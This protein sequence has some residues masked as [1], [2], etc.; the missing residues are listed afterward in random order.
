MCVGW[1]RAPELLFG[2]RH[3]SFAV[4]MW[5]IGAVIAELLTFLP[6]FPG[7]NDI[8]QIFKVFQILGTPTPENWP[9]RKVTSVRYYFTHLR[10]NDNG[11]QQLF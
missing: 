5:A 11:I 3:Y 6:L 2:A 10:A 8:D 4:D 1:Y 9:V 7:G